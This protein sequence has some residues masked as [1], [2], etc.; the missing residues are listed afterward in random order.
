[1]SFVNCYE[2]NGAQDN[3]AQVSEDDVKG[4]KL[5]FMLNEGAG[6]NVFFQTLG[7]DAHPVLLSSHGVVVKDGD[8]YMNA[9]TGIA[10]VETG[11]TT[12]SA[13]YSLSGARQQQLQRGI[14]IVRNSNGTVTKVLVK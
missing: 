1:M 4:G 10:A 9:D 3:I 12:D 5:C 2:L 7:T 8:N 11:K 14:N 13:I 6:Q